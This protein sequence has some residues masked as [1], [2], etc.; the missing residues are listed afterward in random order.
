MAKLDT[1][2]KIKWQKASLE[3]KRQISKGKGAALII[4][5]EKSADL[6]IFAF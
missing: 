4:F 5:I 2:R 1:L 6:L 3:I